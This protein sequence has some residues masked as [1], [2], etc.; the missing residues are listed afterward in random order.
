M[1]FETA[2]IFLCITWFCQRLSRQMHEMEEELKGRIIELDS[3]IQDISP[4]DDSLDS[5]PL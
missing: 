3:K 4:P 2:V 1:G 5:D